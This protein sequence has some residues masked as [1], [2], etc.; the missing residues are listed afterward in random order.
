V[1]AL[2]IDNPNPSTDR[3]RQAARDNYLW[4]IISRDEVNADLPMIFSEGSGVRIRT[5]EG[6]EYLDLM[7]TVS[8]ASTLGYGQEPIADAVSEQLRRLHYGGTAGFQADVT[9]ELAAKLAELAPGRLTSTFFVGSGSEANEAAFKLAH[10]Y[11]RAR[12]AKPRAYKI[13]SRWNDYHGASGGA[14]AASDW[15]GVRRPAEPGVPGYS[16][17]PAPTCYRCPFDL[18]RPSCGLRCAEFLDDHIQHEGPEL[19]SAFIVEP[20][21]QANGVQVPPPGY[22]RR[23]K[24]I[25]EKYEV[26]FIADEIITGFG[27]TGEW[28]GVDHWEIEPDIMTMAKAITSGYIPL[29]ATMTTPEIRDALPAFPD[30]HT[31]GGHPAAAVAALTAISIY[32]GQDL[33]SRAKQSGTSLLESLKSLEELDIVGEV[34]GIGMWAA[35]DFT[36]DKRTREPLA[37]DVLRAIVLRARELGVLVSQNGSAIEVAPPLVIS[38]EDLEEGIARF[39]QAIGEVQNSNVG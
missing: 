23:V 27:R 19:V 22:L 15:L 12:G 14:M 37:D 32:E 24:E 29:G 34:R 31:Y 3:I 5:I 13:V 18:E 38:A 33:V 36:A 35:V 10:F 16:R 17:I 21:M 26:L 7:S 20:V 4:P 30:I 39:K 28:W 1:A 25:C 11:Q 6:E 8:R 9:I 2:D